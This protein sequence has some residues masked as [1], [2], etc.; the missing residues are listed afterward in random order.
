MSMLIAV[1]VACEILFWILLLAGLLS[2][3]VL[4]RRRLG[5]MLLVL[6]PVTDL[7]LLAAT[8]LDLAR[9]ATAEWTHGLAAAYLGFS[10]AFGHGIITRMD[11]RFAHRF[12]GGPAPVTVPKGGPPRVRHEWRQF[13]LTVVAWAIA[14]VLLL[15]AI[16]I[17]GDHDRTA[18][19]QGWLSTLTLVLGICAIWPVSYTLWPGKASTPR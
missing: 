1:I 15:A 19:L 6:V 5:G 2:R 18:A 14:C 17:V 10:V 16:A 4:R 8:V 12:A 7:V 13:G 11:A 3:Y 9:G